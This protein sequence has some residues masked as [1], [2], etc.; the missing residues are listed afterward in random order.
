MF[1]IMNINISGKLFT[2]NP[3]SDLFFH[4]HDSEKIEEGNFDLLLTQKLACLS[5]PGN[6]FKQVCFYLKS[7]YAFYFWTISNMEN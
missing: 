6:N 2:F 7:W 4:L 1:L 5:F 3:E